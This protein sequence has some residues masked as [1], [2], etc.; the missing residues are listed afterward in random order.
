MLQLHAL[1]GTEN[2]VEFKEKLDKL[3]QEREE[4]CSLRYSVL[5]SFSLIIVI[6][7]VLETS[8]N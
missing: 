6:S 3:T 7:L 2:Q 5:L 1:E 4:V 8:Q